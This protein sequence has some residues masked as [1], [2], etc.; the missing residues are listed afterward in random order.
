[1][2]QPGDDHPRPMKEVIPMQVINEFLNN[3]EVGSAKNHANL[4]MFPLFGARGRVPDY[5]TLDEAIGGGWFE[6]SEVSDGGSVPELK[7]VNRGDRAVLMID[8]EE[9]RGAKQNRVLNLTILVPA[10]VTLVVPVSCVEQGR[11]A[12]QSRAMRSTADTLYAKARM[13]K[14]R[15][16]SFSYRASQKPT[17]DQMGL[18][19]EIEQKAKIMGVKSR[20]GAVGDLYE[21]ESRRMGDYERALVPEKGQTGAMFAIDGRLIGFE[22][23]E[24]PDLLRRLLGKIVRSYALD[25]LHRPAG[26]RDL[27]RQSVEQ[28]L[29][30]VAAGKV[31]TFPAVGRGEDLRITGPEITGAALVDGGQIV[32]LCAF[33]CGR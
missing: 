26:K 13:E 11:W 32:H 7:V 5:A 30:E 22:I 1:V 12:M 8:G 4:T 21:S 2:L 17:S 6:V 9:L 19:Q 15:A 24:H 25:A 16:V 27:A 23:F 28:F 20:T 3:V 29:A 18:W 10:G 33:R 14:L 31:Q